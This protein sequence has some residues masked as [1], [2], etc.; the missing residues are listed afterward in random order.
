MAAMAAAPR[1]HAGDVAQRAAA[2]RC[3]AVALAQLH[4]VLGEAQEEKAAGGV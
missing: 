3:G 4:A 2:F 1:A